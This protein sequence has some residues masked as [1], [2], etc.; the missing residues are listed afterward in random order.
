MLLIAAAGGAGCTPASR[1]AADLIVTHGAVWTGDPRHPDAAAVAV[2]GER[3]VDVGSADEIDRWRTSTTQVV[4]AGGRR[5]IPGFNDAHVHFATGGAQLVSVDLRDA[6]S[7]AEFA[8]RIVERARNRPGEWVLGGQWDERRWSP[9]QPPSRDLIDDGTNGT[10]VLVMRWDRR[11]ALAN[12]AALGRAGITEQTPDPVG[13]AI[14]RD[15]R[16]FPTGLLQGTAVDVVARVVPGPTDEERRQ[17]VT[18][19]LEHAASFGVTSVQD[20]NPDPADVAVYAELAERGA[21]TTRIYAVPNETTWFEQAR[22]GIRRAFGSTVLRL[23]GVSGDAVRSGADQLLTRLMAADHAGL[24]LCVNAEEGSAASTLELLA[25]IVRANGE[26]DRRARI[27]HAERARGAEVDRFAAL[28]AVASVQPSAA[29]TAGVVRGFAD[30]GV[31]LA[32]AT[33]WPSA[34]LNPFQAL[35]AASRDV[36]VRDALAA[37]TRGSAFAEF[38]ETAKGVLA[39]GALADI[40]V[41]S[42]DLLSLPADRVGGVTV[43]TTIAGGKVVH[44]RRP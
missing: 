19:A 41:L 3:I 12:A 32:I 2:I 4:D 29:G 8:R 6:G 38:Q 5:V 24:Q 17:T 15:A 20:M 23:G 25:S 34:S 13:G 36:T 37:Y 9:A 31:P 43:V 26:R 30:R 35:A 27:E 33:D 18:R 10:P 21:L 22:I 39:R 16:G 44:Q 14:V 40:V 42:D 28:H 11:T 7:A 1:G